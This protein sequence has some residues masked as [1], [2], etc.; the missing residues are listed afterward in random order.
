MSGPSKR[1]KNVT[2][3]E[4]QND[5]G[6]AKICKRM[7]LKDERDRIVEVEDERG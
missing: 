4:Y 7:L 6:Q 3:S 1:K 5:L 2:K